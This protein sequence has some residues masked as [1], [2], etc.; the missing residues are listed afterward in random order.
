MDHFN[1]VKLML[2]VTASVVKNAHIKS[3]LEVRSYYVI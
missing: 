3:W 2:C 1:V